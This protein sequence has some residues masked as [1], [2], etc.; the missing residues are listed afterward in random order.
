MAGVT[1]RIGPVEGWEGVL[2][3]AAPQFID[4]LM[5]PVGRYSGDGG[6]IVIT[7]GG[8]GEKDTARFEDAGNFT[9]DLIGVFQ[10]FE[11]VVGENNVERIVGVGDSITEAEFGF[12]EIGVLADTRI[13][14]DATDFC[15][16]SSEVHLGDDARSRAQ[17]EHHGFRVKV[18][19]NNF[20]EQLVVPVR[21]VTRI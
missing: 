19:D 5:E 1:C 2:G 13:R 9:E 10:V 8:L 17:I 20:A 14:I 12:V 4:P 15:G 11:D 16:E 3:L 6:D 7:V 18:G 21:R